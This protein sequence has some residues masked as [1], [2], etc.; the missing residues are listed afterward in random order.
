MDQKVFLLVSKRFS[1]FGL[2]GI[3]FL[4]LLLSACEKN[5]T[6]S[7]EE[8]L[9][10]VA[11]PMTGDQSKLGGDLARGVKLA[12]DEWNARGGIGGKQIRLEIGDDVHDPKQAVSVANKMIHL[13]IAGMV[14]HFNSSASIP[15]SSVY[16]DA[17][18]PMITP[19]STNPKLT[20]QGYWNVFRVVGRDDQQGR[21]AAEFVVRKLKAKR[22]AILHDKTT[23]GQGLAGEFRKSLISYKDQG[24]EVL[25]F[26]GVIQGNKDFR[27][28]ITTLKE[29]NPDLYFFGGIFPEGGLLAKQAKEIGLNAPMMSGDGVIDPKFIEIAGAAAEGTYLTFTP[30]PDKMPNAANFLKKYR[31]KY[32]NEL[33]PY[34]IY[35]YDAANILLK[36]LSESNSTDGRTVAETIRRMKYDGALGHIEFDAQ[37]DVKK[38][39]YIVWITK[40][41]KFEEYWKPEG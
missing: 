15:A 13:G 28:I 39:P 40:N 22:V 41:G 24:V 37:G 20:E 18:I 2:L 3:L 35:S 38:A 32:G 14:G 33:A 31:A 10:G 34:A 6:A 4:S 27:G 9:I 26:D 11:G 19:A 7:V 25:S 30:D 16:H 5:G 23:Y 8:I 12:V 29:M 36:A 1:Y 21:V 17:G